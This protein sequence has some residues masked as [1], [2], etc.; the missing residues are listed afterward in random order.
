M[1]RHR[2]QIEQI[3]RQIGEVN[4]DI[5][6]LFSDLSL[7]ILTL[8]SPVIIGDNHLPYQN[9]KQAKEL[10]DDYE[11]KIVLMQKLKEGVLDA[12]GRIRRLKGLIKE[13]EEELNEVY[14][15]LGVI[16]W[17]E[18]SS[19]VLSSEIKRALPSIEERRILFNTVKAEQE[20]KESKKRG[21]H[22]LLKAPLQVNVLLSQWKINKLIRGNREF[23]TTTGKVLADSDLTVALVSEKG[24]ELEQRYGDLKGEIGVCQDEIASLKQHVA[25]SQGSLEGIGVTGSVSRKLIELQ[26]LKREQSQQVGRLAIAYGRFLWTQGEWRS[27]SNET[28]KLYTQIERHEKVRGQLEKQIIELRLEEEIGDLIFLVDQDEERILHLRQTIEQYN[29]QIEEIQKAISLNREKI[30]ILK[31]SLAESLSGEE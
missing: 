1:G 4:H 13:K 22:P 7:H 2:N 18:A 24:P 3:E 25:A 31:R 6:L 28:E 16:A 10:L 8:E 26:T 12:N 17:E 20:N 30:G 21:S 29:R 19:G 23:F 27:L 14:G 5:D 11:R 9:L 15:R